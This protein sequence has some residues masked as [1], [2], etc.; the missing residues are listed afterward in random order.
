[1]LLVCIAFNFCFMTFGG[2]VHLTH[3]AL[4]CIYFCQAQMIEDILISQKP[5]LEIEITWPLPFHVV[6]QDYVLR[7]SIVWSFG[8]VRLLLLALN[9]CSFERDLLLQAA[10]SAILRIVLLLADMPQPAA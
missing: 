5:W 1:M 8:R 10:I 9:S 4:F 3:H 6:T 2:E 7:L